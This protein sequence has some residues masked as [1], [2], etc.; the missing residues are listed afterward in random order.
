MNNNMGLSPDKMNAL[1]NMASKQL[2]TDPEK[3]K[4]QIESGQLDSLTKNMN[5]AAGSQLSKMLSNPKAAEA[6][7]QNPQVQNMLK[8]LL[9]Q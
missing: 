5:P 6:M 1:I 9:G 2:G 7:L 4:Q 8:K 3:L